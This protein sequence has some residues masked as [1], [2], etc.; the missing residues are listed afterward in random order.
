MVMVD[1]ARAALI[2]ALA[3]AVLVHS[4]WLALIYLAAFLSG[5]ARRCEAPPR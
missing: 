1:T 4:A 3:V 2:A 5:P